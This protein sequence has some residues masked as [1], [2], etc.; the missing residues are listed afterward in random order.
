M[1]P[2]N[3]QGDFSM[4][5]K[6]S[7]I[8]LGTA[9]SLAVAG[10]A[11]AATNINLDR[12]VI[13]NLNEACQS[14]AQEIRDRN[15]SVPD[16]HSEMIL[17]A[18]NNDDP[19]ACMQAEE[20][21]ASA[22]QVEDRDTA[23]T[24][25]SDEVTERVELEEQATIEGQAAVM[26]PEPEVDVQVD[27]PQVTVR[28]AQ[29]EVSVQEQAA[30]IQV[31]QPQPTV[32]VQIPEIVVRVE[33]PAPRIFVQTDEPMV[34]VASANPQIEVTQGEPRVTVRQ[35][36]PELRV[37]LGVTSEGEEAQPGE[38]Q[39]AEDMEAGDQDNMNRGGDVD[40]ASNEP[41]VEFVEPEGE[42]QVSIASAEPQVEFRGSEPN[43]S[44]SFTQEPTVE[45]AQI[46][47]AT[48]TFETAEERE[49]RQNQQAQAGGDA[50]QQ[51]AQAEG[52][53]QMPE[54]EGQMILVGD[55]LD[56]EVI[57]ADG[58]DLGEPEALIERDGQLLLV[59][60]EG[61]FLGLGQNAVA[62][63]FDRIAM[64]LDEEKLQ[65]QNLTEEEIEAASDFRYDSSEE[66]AMDR[67]L[68][69]K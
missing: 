56:M 47:E 4:N 17:E 22:D 45:I 24:E 53:Q 32:D 8:I 27:A 15:N 37:D 63:P 67:E 38:P 65:L 39:M 23:Q 58:E 61:G 44:V 50:E 52:E 57:G 21:L 16:D 1:S 64:N 54:T 36:D 26:V 40:V 14:L 41:Q 35:A 3:Q 62:V 59:I 11:S 13:P 42:P 60:E 66:V 55:L 29:P 69:V 9:M 46:G 20:T 28:K 34:E 6:R 7:T 30:R 49:A 68:R 10:G 5:S 12:N 43:V 18:L 2:R 25:T 31:E 33:V 51:Q 19:D 48:V